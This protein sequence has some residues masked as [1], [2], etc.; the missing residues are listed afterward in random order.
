LGKTWLVKE[1]FTIDV[2]GGKIY[3]RLSLITLN[4]IVSPP[5]ALAVGIVMI[6]GIVQNMDWTHG[7]HP[8]LDPK[9]DSKLDPKNSKLEPLLL[10]KLCLTDVNNY[11]N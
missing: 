4:E 11:Y 9:L 7:L 6:I 1:A 5:R 3:G 2:N 8:K 10:V